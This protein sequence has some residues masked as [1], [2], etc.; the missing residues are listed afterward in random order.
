MKFVANKL[1]NQYLMNFL[2]QLDEDIESIS[3]VLAA[4]AYG[5]NDNEKFVENCL[6]N[7]FRLDI[8]MRYDH[9][10]PVAPELLRKLNQS[11][12]NVFC[13]LIRDYLHSKVMWWKGYGAYIGSANLTQRAWN[14]NIEAG[15]FL[16][17]DEL[18]INGLDE[19]LKSFFET[20]SKADYSINLTD[21]II[22]EQERI[23]RQR[24]PRENELNQL[25][26]DLIIAKSVSPLSV[27]KVDA[28]SRRFDSFKREWLGTITLLREIAEKID[29]F[30]PAWLTEEYPVAWQADQ[31]LHAYYYGYVRE[32]HG[33]AIPF[34]DFHRRH[35][36]NPAAAL[37][38]ALVWWRDHETPPSGEDGNLKTRRKYQEILAPNFQKL[39]EE[40]LLYICTHTFALCEHLRKIAPRTMGYLTDKEIKMP[41]RCQWHAKN[42]QEATNGKG[43]KIEQLLRF[44][45]YDHDDN[46][47]KAIENLFMSTNDPQYKFDR[48]GLSTLAEIIGWVRPEFMPP[49]N[50]RTSKAL[51]A[52]GY[53]VRLP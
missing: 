52:L 13:R 18:H 2:P 36:S 24:Q 33:R 5:T 11:G 20:L 12:N 32:E 38:E 23:K 8:W 39:S 1:N 10:V 9:T 30:R 51:Y 15:L 14:S 42:L 34:H 49:R 31:F 40:E 21:E 26:D 45:L 7:R 35:E 47:N 48:V 29:D 46:I 28:T 44:V 50:G 17:D 4:I 3:Q 27:N 53:P 43:W 41:I 19:E 22:E 16:N 6:E 37:E 25:R